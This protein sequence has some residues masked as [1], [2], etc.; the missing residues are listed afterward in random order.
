MRELFFIDKRKVNGS[1]QEFF[2]FFF[3]KKEFL[4]DFS[5]TADISIFFA[6]K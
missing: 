5:Y 2:T 3:G 6:N 4:N 1:Q